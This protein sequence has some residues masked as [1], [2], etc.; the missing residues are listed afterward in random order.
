MTY[1][2]FCAKLLAAMKFV[3]RSLRTKSL[4]SLVGLALCYG[5][6][7]WWTHRVIRQPFNLDYYTRYISLRCSAAYTAP[8]E[9]PRSRERLLEIEK[10]LKR[11]QSVEV[12]VDGIWGGIVGSPSVR[13]KVL[14]DGG[15][16]TQFKYYLVDVSP[17]LG[18]AFIDY[19]LPP[20]LYYLNI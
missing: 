18:T 11:C 14:F 13:L 12:R 16:D 17:I 5:A 1:C 15:A 9:H 2:R 8:A 20:T 4:W 3:S 19:E 10:A 7:L 6:A